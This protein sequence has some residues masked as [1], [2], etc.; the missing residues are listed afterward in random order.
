MKARA[1]SLLERLLRLS[2]SRMVLAYLS[3]AHEVT[4]IARE[5][6]PELTEV[7]MP[8]LAR[9]C[10]ETLHHLSGHPKRLLEGAADPQSNRSFAEMILGAAVQRRWLPF[11]ERAVAHAESE[12]QKQGAGCPSK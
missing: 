9:A 2:E 4:I 5:T 6:Y 8:D 11:L 1:D 12:S 3:Y 10:N 7:P